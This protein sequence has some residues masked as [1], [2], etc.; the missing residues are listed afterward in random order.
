M[1]SWVEE[2]HILE[3]LGA[4]VVAALV[5]VWKKALEDAVGIPHH[6]LVEVVLCPLQEVGSVAVVV[7]SAFDVVHT[8]H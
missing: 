8:G 1:T 5:V 2:P 4:A 6:Q 3:V 7:A